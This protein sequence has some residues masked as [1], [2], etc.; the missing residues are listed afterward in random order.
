MSA[1]GL[2]SANGL[3]SA[4]GLSSANG[5]MTTDAGRKTVAYLVRC[6]LAS[7]DTLV[8][9]DQ[10]FQWYTFP[11]ALGLCQAWKY[12]GI[13]GNTQANRTCEN[14]L[15]ACLMAHTNTDGVHVPIWLDSEASQIGWGTSPSYPYQEGTYF[16]NIM[17]TGDLT[18]QG[19]AGVVGPVAYFC[20]GYSFNDKLVAG[21]LGSSSTTP[22]T[23][24]FG[25]SPY[26]HSCDANLNKSYVTMTAHWSNGTNNPDGS[27]KP[28]DGY[29]AIAPYTGNYS[30]PYTW[31]SGEPITV[32]RTTTVTNPAFDPIYDYGLTPISQT[33]STGKPMKSVDA[34]NNPPKPGDKMQIHATAPSDDQKFKVI[35]DGGGNNYNIKSK[36]GTLCFDVGAS[37]AVGGS[38]T[39][40]SCDT[41]AATNSQSWVMTWTTTPSSNVK[42]G[43][44][45][46]KNLAGGICLSLGSS[47]SDGAP[48]TL[49]SCDSTKP[50]QMFSPSPS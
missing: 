12:G 9:Q 18:G 27:H 20:E 10:N 6:A 30:H 2:S 46:L 44:Y 39:L 45:Q 8:K 11:G 50:D 36:D 28:A 37:P 32:W 23:N 31:Q 24:A 35:R 4:N 13:H 25:T 33:D 43:A 5:L 7:G 16:G 26:G 41:P 15:S 38:V 29:Q 49:Q 1:N 47:S 21:R 40:V 48:M 3:I 34:P 17:E 22:Y 14:I 19:M 42:K